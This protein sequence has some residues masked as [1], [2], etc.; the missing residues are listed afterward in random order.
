MSDIESKAINSTLWSL[1]ETL[2]SQGIQFILGI[3]LARLL[4]PED[5][6]LVAVIY[7]FVGL[8]TVI[9]D[10]GFKT[11]II[12]SKDITNSETSTIFWYNI[13][14]SFVVSSL[15]FSAANSISIYFHKSQL[16]LIL[17]VFSIVPIINSLGLVQNA[18]MFKNLQFKLNTKIT[19]I[20]N[21]FSGV[22]AIIFA[23]EGY[24]YWSLVAK[25]ILQGIF[26]TSLFWFYNK[27]RPEY[28][29]SINAFKK[30]FAFSNKLL[31]V[32]LIDTAFDQI[33]SLI[34]GKYYSFQ[35]LGLYKRGEGF[36]ELVS[37]SFSRAIQKVNSPILSLII[38]QN[39]DIVSPHR[40]I[41]TN[42][43]FIIY[44]L[45]LGLAAIA[46]PLI[47]VLLGD[48]WM[49]SVIFLQLLV[50]SRLAYPIINSGASV[51]EVLGRSDLNLKYTLYNR[52][53]LIL[54]L[55][56]STQFG[57]LSLIIG[58]II[59]S[60]T[61]AIIIM[62]MLE[63]TTSL[64]MKTQIND[65]FRILLPTLL[66]ALITYLLIF[67]LTPY[68]KPFYLLMLGVSVGAFSFYFLSRIFNLVELTFALNTLNKLLYII[69]IK[70]YSIFKK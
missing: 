5:Y 22:I 4:T 33:Y 10:S 26:I 63:Q 60:I 56:F 23:M 41:V 36:V 51:L 69:R 20:S 54:V 62:Y 47:F 32:G 48:K 11:S 34:I 43:C 70:G 28:V 2:G 18:L 37:T 35:E 19:L 64:N 52:S 24:E 46:S 61:S 17:K 53:F 8:S 30:H 31:I 68:L 67:M 59:H 21:V 45:L 29:F 38:F 50:F 16:E 44:P 14:V 13:V 42:S 40:K 9:I 6:G 12:R 1:L 7:V 15:L 49:P 55:F 66:M 25:T 39:N 57:I 27:W 65:I 3:I 58:K